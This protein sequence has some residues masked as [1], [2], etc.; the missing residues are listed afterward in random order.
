[1]GNEAVV[2]IAGRSTIRTASIHVINAVLLPAMLGAAV[3]LRIARLPGPAPHE[4]FAGGPAHSFAHAD[5]IGARRLS[6]YF[7][8]SESRN[9][10]ATTPLRGK[11][12]MFRHKGPQRAALVV[13]RLFAL[14][15]FVP[16]S[17]QKPRRI[18]LRVRR[19][20]S[21]SASRQA[22]S[23]RH[24]AKRHRQESKTP[25]GFSAIGQPRCQMSNSLPDGRFRRS[26]SCM[27]S[28]RRLARDDPRAHLTASVWRGFVQAVGCP[29]TNCA[30]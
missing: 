26:I 4:P 24:R 17:R 15:A 19:P 18:G 2:T 1:M 25:R 8:V 30:R 29:G 14:G 9:V 6:Q 5:A 13:F 22:R 3:P 28:N 7:S 16:A 11:T 23:R 27:A 21:S 12:E 20:S 10:S